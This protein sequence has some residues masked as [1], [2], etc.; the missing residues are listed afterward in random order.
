MKYLKLYE[1]QTNNQVYFLS[2]ALYSYEYLII[3]NNKTLL[4]FITR[5]FQTKEME[6]NNINTT[7]TIWGPKVGNLLYSALMSHYNTPIV[8]SS[9]MS[10]YAKISFV[11]KI[12]SNN[13]NISQ[14]IKGISFYSVYKE[15][16][17]LNSILELKQ[18]NR[19]TV[20]DGKELDKSIREEVRK[21]HNY[22]SDIFMRDK[23]INYTFGE[24]K[25]RFEWLSKKN[26]RKGVTKVHKTNDSKEFFKTYNIPFSYEGNQSAQKFLSLI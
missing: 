24:S 21:K 23:E 18:E 26:P 10:D 19:V 11:K 9:N 5:G 8:G 4:G 20:L 15:E 16:Q 7:G 25:D 22:M 1:E 14:P 13:F 3:V 2:G 6:D 17:I 12:K